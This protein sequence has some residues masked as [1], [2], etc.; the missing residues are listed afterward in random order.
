MLFITWLNYLVLGHPICIFSLDF[1][2]SAFLHTLYMVKMLSFSM[3]YSNIILVSVLYLDHT[4][5]DGR[6]VAG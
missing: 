2:C 3:G 1:N 6:T 5:L 4:A